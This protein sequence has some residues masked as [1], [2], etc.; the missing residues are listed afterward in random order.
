MMIY[1]TIQNGIL[2]GA[3]KKRLCLSNKA[4]LPSLVNN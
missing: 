1:K 4:I 3:E 2:I